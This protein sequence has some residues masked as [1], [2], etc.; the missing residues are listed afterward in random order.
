MRTTVELPDAVFK[1]LK[2]TAAMEGTSL[3]AL[4]LRGVE[5]ELDSR[6][7]GPRKRVKLPLIQGKEKRR[8][9]LAVADLDE[10]LFG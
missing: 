6:G 5:R 3:K 1:R 10:L 9:S 8:L 4:L 2:A 7:R